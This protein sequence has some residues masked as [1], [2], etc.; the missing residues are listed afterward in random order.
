[1]SQYNAILKRSQKRNTTPEEESACL[2]THS[3]VSYSLQ[4]HLTKTVL[5]I[6]LLTLNKL[7]AHVDR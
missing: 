1:M 5:L 6:T 3:H 4:T 2:S 7:T